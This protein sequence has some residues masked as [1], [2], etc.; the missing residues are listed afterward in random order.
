MNK[1]WAN[2]EAGKK[3]CTLSVTSCAMAAGL[4]AAVRAAA[5]ATLRIRVFIFVSG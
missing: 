3:W 2:D 1:V 5:A 4:N